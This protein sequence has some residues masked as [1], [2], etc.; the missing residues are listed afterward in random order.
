MILILHIFV[1]LSSVIASTASYLSPSKARLRL[2]Y[3]LTLLTLGSGTY[4]VWSTRSPL[5]SS[6]IT[7]LIYLGVVLSGVLGAWRKLARER[8]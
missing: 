7:G 6:C 1:A 2:T 4:L 8:A 3:G 5:L